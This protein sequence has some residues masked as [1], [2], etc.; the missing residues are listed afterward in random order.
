MYIRRTSKTVNGKTYINHLLVESHHTPDGPRQRV[1]CS[2]GSLLPGPADQWLTVAHR[3]QSALAGQAS[4]LEDPPL[5]TLL[6]QA[7]PAPPTP[8]ISRRVLPPQPVFLPDELT[9]EQAHAAGA[10]HA[11]HQIWLRLGLPA[12]LQRIGLDE[13]AQLLTEVMTLN[14]LIE[15]G[16]EYAMPEW[17]NRTALS[18]ILETDLAL[19]NDTAL[20]RNL[21]KLHP[22]R[23]TIETELAARE[24]S[25]FN[26]RES[27]Y[28]YDLTSTYFEGKQRRNPKAKRGYSRDQRPDCKQVV[29]GLVLDGDGFPKAHEIFDGN[30]IDTTTVEEMLTTLERRTAGNRAATVVVDRGMAS[31]ANLKQIA[32]RGYTWLVAAHQT[33]RYRHESAFIDTEGWVPAEPISPEHPEQNKSPVML[34]RLVHAGEIHLLCRSNHRKDK[35]RAIRE[36]HEKRLRDG[37]ERLTKRVEKKRLKTEGQIGEAIGRLRQ[38]HSRVSRYFRIEFNSAEHKLHWGELEEDKH[39]AEQLDGAYLLK[40]NRQDMTAAEMWR[41][42][43]LLTRVEAAFRT[44]KTPLRERPIF[45]QLERRVVTHIFLCVLAY[46]LVVCIEHALRE[47]GIHWCWDTVR[48]TLSTHQVVTVRLPTAEGPVLSIRKPTTPEPEHKAIYQ[49]LGVPEGIMKAV[50]TWT[51]K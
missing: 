26:L 38:R 14:R 34:K 41:T 50:K 3:L 43:M 4:L 48:K 1:I 33:E 9:M 37:L 22:H 17:A 45:H 46:H 40:T 51:S 18:D 12:I 31:K 21:D 24:R 13:R 19:L 15:P 44:L 5:D 30:R 32:G 39:R 16:S 6:Q 23:A 49:A 25:L 35:D 36:L 27:I 2:L 11:G 29:I 8:A 28:L 47:R 42:Y 7:Q 20:Y 10:V